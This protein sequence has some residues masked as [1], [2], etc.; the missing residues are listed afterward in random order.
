M[1][2]NA[3]PYLE[4]FLLF[5]LFFWNLCMYHYYYYEYCCTCFGR[6]ACWDDMHSMCKRP[7]T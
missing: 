6:A 1:Y 5:V 3:A 7:T 4:A 2:K